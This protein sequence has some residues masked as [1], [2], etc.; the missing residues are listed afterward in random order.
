MTMM[1]SR[2]I[3]SFN[4]D[5]GCE[6]FGQESRGGAVWQE[7]SGIWTGNAVLCDK[8]HNVGNYSSYNEAKIA[9]E[10]EFAKMVQCH[11]D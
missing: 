6:V 1:E 10:V 11:E 3:W 8:I 4:P 5:T 7:E 9:V 2:P